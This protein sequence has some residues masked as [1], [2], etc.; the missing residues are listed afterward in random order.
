MDIGQLEKK[1]DLEVREKESVIPPALTIFQVQLHTFTQVISP[2][3]ENTQKLRCFSQAYPS[4][5]LW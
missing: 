4:P 5:Y 2:S 3:P 1:V